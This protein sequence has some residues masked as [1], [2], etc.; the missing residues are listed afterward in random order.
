MRKRWW[1]GGV[2]VVLSVPQMVWAASEVDILLNKLV[3]RGVLTNADA[4]DIRDEMQR[5]KTAN[6]KQLAQEIVPESARNWKW[7]G[8][9]RLREEYR[10]RTGDGTDTNRQRIRFRYGF[11]AKVADDLKVGARLATGSTAD[12]IS[13]NQSFNS[14]FNHKTIVLDRAYVQYTP[15]LA[16]LTQTMLSGGVIANPFWTVGQLM[17]DDD[18]NFDGAA[19]KLTKE[20]GPSVTLFTND[21]VFSLNTD[22]VQSSTLWSVQGGVTLKP[23]VDSTQETLKHTKITGALAYHDYMNVTGKASNSTA[24]T[25]AGGTKGNSSGLKDL[26][27][28]N[29]TFELA[30]DA[31]GVPVS[32]FADWVHNTGASTNDNGFQIGLKVGKAKKPLDLKEGWE[33]GYYFERLDPDATFGAFTDSDFGN[34][35]TNHRGHVW[36]MKLAMLS[37]STLQLKYMNTQELKGAKNHADTFQADWVTT[38]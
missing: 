36:W 8:D 34:G 33:G 30:S 2:M 7:S 10:N 22:V 29:P 9:I 26:N 16:G 1:W 31:F 4:T 25:N 23:F 20:L 21:G 24:I 19:V 37:H 17:W 13:T 15:E 5:E 18:L 27:L 35:G 3:T 28:F 32:T 12:P 14:S 38:F 11:D 6:T